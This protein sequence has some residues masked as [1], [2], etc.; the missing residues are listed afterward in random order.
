[1]SQ[2]LKAIIEREIANAYDVGHCHGMN[3][4]RNFNHQKPERVGEGWGKYARKLLRE[5]KP[6]LINNKVTKG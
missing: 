3:P 4:M 1:M 2:K 5:L 6:F